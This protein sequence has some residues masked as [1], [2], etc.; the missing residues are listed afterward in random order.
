MFGYLD[1]GSGSIIVSALAAGTAGVTVAARMG[2]RKVKRRF[3]PGQADDGGPGDA[4][5]SDA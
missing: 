5:P 1:A 2:M 3:R 4:I